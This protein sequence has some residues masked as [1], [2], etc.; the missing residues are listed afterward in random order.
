[1]PVDIAGDL[2]LPFCVNAFLEDYLAKLE[3]RLLEMDCED[4]DEGGHKKPIENLWYR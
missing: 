2:N 1:L 3:A 4:D